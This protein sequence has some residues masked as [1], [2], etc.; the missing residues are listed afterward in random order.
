MR[1]KGFPGGISATYLPLRLLPTIAGDLRDKGLIPGLGRSPGGG[2]QYSCLENP[3]DRGGW[4]ATV[5]RIA[6]LDRTEATYRACTH[7]RNKKIILDFNRKISYSVPNLAGLWLLA[8][9]LLL[10]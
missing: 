4:Q 2:L 3:R 6:E 10:F 7:I 8:F 9:A 5:H 1:N